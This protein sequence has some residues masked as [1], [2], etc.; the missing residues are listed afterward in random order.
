[1]FLSS[2]ILILKHGKK[3]LHDLKEKKNIS[4]NKSPKEEAKH[5]KEKNILKKLHNNVKITRLKQS[6]T[7]KHIQTKGLRLDVRQ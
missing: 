4:S 6:K 7:K 2:G 1:M 5:P 3:T